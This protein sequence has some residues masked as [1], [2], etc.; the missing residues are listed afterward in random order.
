MC[1]HTYI[2][3]F[4]IIVEGNKKGISSKEE[5][6]RQDAGLRGSKQSNS[7]HRFLRPLGESDQIILS[8]FISQG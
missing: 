1:I 2:L 5:N 3:I 8:L 7:V 6:Q 4:I